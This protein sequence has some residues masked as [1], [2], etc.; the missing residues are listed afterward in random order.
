[1]ERVYRA[2]DV[3]LYSL[4]PEEAHGFHHPVECPAATLIAPVR[5]VQ[6]ARSVQTDSN[7]KVVLAQELTPL[8]V[9]Q[10]AVSLNRMLNPW[11]LASGSA[12]P[13]QR[14]AGRSPGP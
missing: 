13:F 10:D 7:Q 9:Q 6:V 3:E 5:V 1:M 14:R 4:L 12:L 2:K 11:Y 8:R